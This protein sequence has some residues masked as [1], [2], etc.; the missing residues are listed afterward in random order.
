[1]GKLSLGRSPLPL[2]IK[3][4]MIDAALAPCIV[5]CMT[6]VL[7]AERQWCTEEEWQAGLPGS[8]PFNIGNAWMRQ[9]IRLGNYELSTT[10][11]YGIAT[12]SL[13]L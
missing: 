6:N 9:R 5:H 2:S 8:D 4:P 13:S 10:S 1:M 3:R 12:M 11:I 7:I